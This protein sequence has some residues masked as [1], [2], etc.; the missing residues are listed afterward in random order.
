MPV[1]FLQ[2]ASRWKCMRRK[3]L[4]RTLHVR[5]FSYLR[6]YW[7][8]K[9]KMQSPVH[10]WELTDV[11][12][13]R[14]LWGYFLKRRKSYA[15]WNIP[16]VDVIASPDRIYTQTLM[17]WKCCLMGGK[18]KNKNK[19]QELP[20]KLSSSPVQNCNTSLSF[21]WSEQSLIS[22]PITLQRGNLK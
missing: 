20:L 13:G 14:S 9:R 5:R 2:A 19:N 17:L 15:K 21:Q 16:F 8:W 22:W 18:P 7:W 3:S 11:F 4:A 12:F 1:S 6:Y 10:I